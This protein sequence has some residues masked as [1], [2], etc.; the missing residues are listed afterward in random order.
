MS[1]TSF[2]FFSCFLVYLRTSPEICMERMKARCRSEEKT[3][4]MVGDIV[5]FYH[6]K[7]A[8][9]VVSHLAVYLN[10]KVGCKTSVLPVISNAQLA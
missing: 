9:K 4:P 3:I 8:L 7:F 10:E 6:R 5:V 1:L 2:I